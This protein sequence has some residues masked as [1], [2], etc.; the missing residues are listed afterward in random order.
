MFSHVCGPPGNSL[1]AITLGKYPWVC[2]HTWEAALQYCL[3]P[4]APRRAHCLRGSHMSRSGLIWKLPSLL[5]CTVLS[6]RI[7][8]S[9]FVKPS[10]FW[11]NL[12]CGFYEGGCFSFVS[13]LGNQ[14]HELD[15][16]INTSPWG[17]WR[18]NLMPPLINT[19]KENCQSMWRQITLR[20]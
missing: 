5:L 7:V 8:V 16:K 12:G 19:Y 13:F 20:I 6:D 15:V 10:T 2:N 18:N 9:I 1:N 11:G 17:K 14:P 3:P 4:P